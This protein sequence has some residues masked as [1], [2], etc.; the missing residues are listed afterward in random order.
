V[1][2]VVVERNFDPPLRAEAL[3]AAAR[4]CGSGL[5][6]LGI[7]W[8]ESLV[9]RHGRRMLHLFT[10]PS[11]AAVRGALRDQTI[12]SED[13]WLAQINALASRATSDNGALIVAERRIA[14]PVRLV[15]LRTIEHVCAWCLE[16]HRIRLVRML[17]SADFTRIVY[18][19]TAPDAESV[20]WAH[21]QA[22]LPLDAVWPCREVAGSRPLADSAGIAIARGSE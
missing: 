6:K 12:D 8:R 19:F 7:T 17:S 22:S 16:K 2:D 10:A 20:R 4:P 1:P 13:V 11:T 21:R 9:D 3:E 15:D 5:A 14:L 18:V